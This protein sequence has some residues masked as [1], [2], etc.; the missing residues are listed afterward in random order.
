MKKVEVML[1]DA[2]AGRSAILEQALSDAGYQITVRTASTDR[3]L[4]QVREARPDVILIDIDLPDRDTLE[5]LREIGQDQPR[6]IVMF[7]E[8]SDPETTAAALRAGVSAYVVDDINPRRLQPIMDVAIARFREYQAAP[9]AGGNPQPL[10]RTQ[11]GRK[12]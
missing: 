4:Q 12:S 10:G 5:Q 9:G 11:G 1:I 2:H 7:A 6:P 3:L 8:R